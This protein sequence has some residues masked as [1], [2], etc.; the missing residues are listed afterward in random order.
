M[1]PTAGDI[2]AKLKV[3]DYDRPDINTNLQFGIY[4]LSE[5][6]RRLDGNKLQAVFSYNAGIGRIRQLLKTAKIEFEKNSIPED[7]F[8]EALP[9][10]ETRDYGRK[11]VGASAMYA[12][13]YY[14]KDP[15]EIIKDFMEN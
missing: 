9:I 11:I 8:L 14:D 15:S 6:S 3:K 4:Y 10:Q 2:A 12:M 13:L 7:I 1:A 5:L